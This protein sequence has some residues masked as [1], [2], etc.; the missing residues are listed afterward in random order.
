MSEQRLLFV[1]GGTGGH[2]FPALAVAAQCRQLQPNSVIEFVGT[3]GR[4][5]EKIVP[6]Q[7]YP[8]NFLWISGLERKIS[9]KTLLFPL[10]V[11]VAV[12]QAL[13]LIGRFRPDA[14]ICAGAYVSWPMGIAARIRRVPLVLMASDARPGLALSK[15]AAK[16]SQI[17][18]AF[19]SAADHFR[20]LGAR[21]PILL[22]GNPVRSELL[23]PHD[24]AQARQ[25]FGLRPDR[26]T[27]FAVGGSLGARSINNALD[28]VAHKFRADGVQLIWQTGTSYAGSELQE[29]DLYRSTFINQMELAYAA[30]D[31]VVAR[32]GA[33]TV[34]ELAVVGKPSVL[35]P[36]PIETVH[37]RQNAEAMQAAGGGVM[38]P[39]SQVSERLYPVAAGLLS[40]PERLAEMGRNVAAL[41]VR[42]ADRRIAKEIMELH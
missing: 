17:H 29:P 16:A 23:A 39:D 20:T 19:D 34:S 28:A 21:C 35:I 4:M 25:H 3:R 12:A 15:L 9:L 32:A 8:L 27:I 37:Q 1:A 41:A 26:P 5:E 24:A 42:D 38:I 36:L 30:A 13:R 33:M 2:L 6:R 40:D 31:L 11:V 7:G 22:S 14:V 10:K 18:V